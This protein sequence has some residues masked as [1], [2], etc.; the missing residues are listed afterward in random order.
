MMSAMISLAKH[1]LKNFVQE[2][3]YP[4]GLSLSRI[5]SGIGMELCLK[6]LAK[7]GF[8]PEYIVDVGAARGDW[9]KVAL[10]SWPHAKYFL[11]EPLEERR[12]DLTTLNQ[13]HANVTF[14]I[15]AAGPESGELSIGV[16]RD[17]YGSSFMYDGES[18]RKVPVLTIDDLLK[19]GRL[20][21]PDFMKLDVQGYE[22]K[23]LEGSTRAM[24][25]CELIL[26]E[27]PFFRFSPSMKL[28]HETIEWMA[29]RGWRPYEI[30]DTLR[31]PFDGAM[32]QCDMLFAREGTWLL[33]SDTWG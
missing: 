2:I 18:S 29:D 31:R 4:F 10:L 5:D 33:D 13:K 12:A 23:V 15:A 25:N 7:R 28:L 6:G 24:E 27:L 11:F 26:L 3:L 32:G 16:T 19:E 17:L 22:L 20:V 30:V 14:T 1:H 9:T 8:H 21:Q